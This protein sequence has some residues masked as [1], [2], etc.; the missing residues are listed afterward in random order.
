MTNTEYEQA[1]ESNSDWLKW[2]S[3]HDYDPTWDYRVAFEHRGHPLLCAAQRAA[4]RLCKDAVEADDQR[5]PFAHTRVFPVHFD[6]HKAVATYVMGTYAE[7][8]LLVS[9][10]AHET[11]DIEDQTCAIVDS[12][13]HE[14]RHAIQ[15]S[16]DEDFDEDAAEYGSDDMPF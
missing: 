11:V 14:L 2:A 12:V 7:P 10:E 16:R 9:I 15:D 1:C 13:I 8:V 4:D 3:T 5:V 6:N